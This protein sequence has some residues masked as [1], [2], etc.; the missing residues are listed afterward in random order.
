M[1]LSLKTLP[2]IGRLQIPDFQ[3]LGSK[4]RETL[5]RPNQDGKG[6][7]PVLF[8]QRT[9]DLAPA[10]LPEAQHAYPAHEQRPCAGFGNSHHQSDVVADA[11]IIEQ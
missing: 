8:S 5:C 4:K 1:H 10:A 3:K 9:L 11:G 7:S 2:D 6:S